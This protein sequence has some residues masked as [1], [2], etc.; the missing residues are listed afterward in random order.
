MK[1]EKGELSE[2]EVEYFEDLIR[3]FNNRDLFT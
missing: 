3:E 1:K 2:D